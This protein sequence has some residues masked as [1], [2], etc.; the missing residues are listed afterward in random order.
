MTMRI[1]VTGIN[2][3][4]GRHLTRELASRDHQVIGLGQDQAAAEIKQL[5]AD[6]HRCDL[7]DPAQVARLPLERVDAVINLAGLAR[8]GESFDAEA[9]FKKVNVEVVTHLGEKLL[10]AN[11]Q[12][13]L[14]AVSSGTVYDPHQPLPLTEQSKTTQSGSPYAMSKLMMEAAV[15]DLRERGLQ[16][17]IVRPFNHTGPGQGPGFLIPDLFQ[18]LTAF[19]ETGEA[20][21]VGNLS[22]KRD[23]TDVRDVAK[24]YA[25]LAA[26]ETLEFDLYNIC[27]S[28]SHAGQEILDIMATSM[29]LQ[30]A[31][32]VETDQSLIRPTDPLDVYGSYD[33]LREETGWEPEIPLEQTIQD[34][35]NAQKEHRT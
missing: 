23:Y 7:T 32:K 26:S 28:Q 17:I 27:S 14:I 12:A 35:I 24:A 19:K 10:L 30:D 22:T 20:V 4:V 16:C 25:D 34:F 29:G 31:V 5:L 9:T 21:R 2:G 3:F 33:R 13:R 15:R 18:K 6:Y 8:Q 11:P 1:V